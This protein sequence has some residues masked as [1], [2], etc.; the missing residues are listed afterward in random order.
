[1]TAFFSQ[2]NN[3]LL[4]WLNHSLQAHGELYP[5]VFKIADHGGE[6]VTALAFVWIWF[7][8]APRVKSVMVAVTSQGHPK[9]LAL[10][11]G[12]RLKTHL[13]TTW[14]TREDSR[15]QALALGTAGMAAYVV[16]RMVAFSFNTTRPFATQL[17]IWGPPGAF[18]GLRNL[19]SFPRDHATLLGLIP[20][21]L[22]FWSRRSLLVSL[23]LALV[24]MT[25]RVAI[26]FHYP[27]DMVAGAVLG[28]LF[29]YTA[30]HLYEGESFANRG[31]LAL[32]RWFDPSD[33]AM[34]LIGYTL[35]ALLALEFAMH[36]QH[37]FEII[38][39]FR[40]ELQN[41]LHRS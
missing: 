29:A 41:T 27:A 19:G 12:R 13:P 18:N 17:P 15:A 40:A 5:L 9:G 37:V 20:V 26:G 35:L 22:A 25:A 34:C 28:S 1:M 39:W 32:A 3:A 4:L 7:W 6:A 36:F 33:W 24:C 10:V 23:P 8:R 16:A 38:F 2:L 11:R 30:M 21:G 14:K 31:W